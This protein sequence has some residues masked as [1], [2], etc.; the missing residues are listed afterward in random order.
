MTSTKD[1][2]DTK[3]TNAATATTTTVEEA[4]EQAKRAFALKKYESSVEHYATALEL[5]TEKA[6]EDAPETADLYFS[7][8]KA[9]LENAIAQTSVLGK[10]QPEEAVE[11]E[12][13]KGDAEEE[14]GD[15]DPA[16]DIFAQAQKAEEDDEEEDE[17]EDGEP[18]DDFNAAWEVLDLARAIYEK[19]K[20]AD[21]DE[22]V[23]LKLADTYIALGDV[24]LETEKFEQAITDY[25]TAL[26]LKIDLLPLSSR[27][28]AEAE[29]KLSIA[30]D[31]TSGRLSDAIVHAE[32]A[33]KS[34][35]TR[36]AELREGPS[37]QPPP[38]PKDDPKGKGKSTTRRLVR[39]DLVQNM[40]S[41]QIESEIK[42]L[43]GLKDD[44][45]LK[46]E[47]LKTSPN[48]TTTAT[49]PALAAEALDKELNVASSTASVPVTVVN[50]LTSMVV[51]KK[52]KVPQES[53]TVKRKADADVEAES[54]PTEKKARLDT[55]V[56]DP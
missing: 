34:V 12:E 31:L 13:S 1:T 51:K 2:M 43:A 17:E 40:T 8:G 42:E 48:H 36:L 46:V 37:A 28:I 50:D 49:A 9:L 3:D 29:Y 4:V 41:A 45:A 38:P 52:K 33:L 10:D 25:E 26:A 7:Y 32:L 30:L 20:E 18:E 6:G 23:R 22:E 47:E 16:V 35:E 54:S 19:Q 39:D 27:H 15:D 14:A 56:A 44:L 24:S 5:L 11:V 21:D 55:D 53:A